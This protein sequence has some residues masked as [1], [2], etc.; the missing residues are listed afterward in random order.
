M[1]TAQTICYGC[2][3][4]TTVTGR[5]IM[6]T[7]FKKLY[8]QKITSGELRG[9]DEDTKFLARLHNDQLD[10]IRR[11]SKAHD[12]VSVDSC[13]I[14]TRTFCGVELIASNNRQL[15]LIIRERLKHAHVK[16]A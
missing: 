6:A 3:I 11:L 7:D 9:S 13:P 4:L 5:Y 1:D 12:C 14:G 10:N 8:S 15:N 2:N 16:V